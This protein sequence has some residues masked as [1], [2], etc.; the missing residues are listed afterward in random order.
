MAI[1]GQDVRQALHLSDRP[2]LSGVALVPW[3]AGGGAGA[4]G[5]SAVGAGAMGSTMEGGRDAVARQL[6]AAALEALAP[7]GPPADREI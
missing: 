3:S 5:A 1:E 6:L 7:P 4:M 2:D